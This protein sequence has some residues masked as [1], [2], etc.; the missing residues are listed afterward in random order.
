MRLLL[1]SFV[2]SCGGCA[3]SEPLISAPDGTPPDAGHPDAAEPR[4]V[5]AA[6]RP[7]PPSVP[8][9]GP[10]FDTASYLVTGAEIG[11]TSATVSAVL[12]DRIELELGDG[13][14]VAVPWVGPDLTAAFAVDEIVTLTVSPL[15]ELIEGPRATLA[16]RRWGQ[17]WGAP[18]GTD[19]RITAA[20][21]LPE[22]GMGE[23]A[24]TRGGGGLCDC[25]TGGYEWTTNTVLFGAA[26]TPVAP[27]MT[28]EIEGW[29]VTNVVASDVRFLDTC[30]AGAVAGDSHSTFLRVVP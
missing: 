29:M 16:R 5:A 7:T 14:A 24:C 20:G 25:G 13:G 27:G 3:I 9:C 26:R 6:P 18:W 30:R 28:A 22:L 19:A 23:A 1:L 21:P 12:P 2:L 8:A 15:D 10:E 4:C 17:T 11:S